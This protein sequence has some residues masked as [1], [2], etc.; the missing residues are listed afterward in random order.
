[1]EKFLKVCWQH[2]TFSGEANFNID[3]NFEKGSL[4]EQLGENVK[5]DTVSDEI[6]RLILSGEISDNISG[7]KYAMYKGCEPKLFTEVVKELENVKKIERNGDKR[8]SSTNIH[9]LIGKNEYKIQRLNH[10]T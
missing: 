8:Y 5:K 1:M 4:F 9:R 6:K 7:L 2:D 3:N 10:G